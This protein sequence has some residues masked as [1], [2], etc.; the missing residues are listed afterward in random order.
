MESNPGDKVMAT[1]RIMGLCLLAC[2][3]SLTACDCESESSPDELK[4]HFVNPQDGQRLGCLDDKERSTLEQLEFDIEALVILKSADA[5]GLSARLSFGE[6]EYLEEVSFSGQV[7]FK[8]LSLALGSHQLSLSLLEGEEELYAEKI[9][10]EVSFD[11]G[12]PDCQPEKPPAS[13][14]FISP[15]EGKIFSAEDDGEGNLGDGIQI[16]VK[17]EVENA[18]EVRLSLGDEPQGSQAVL[19]GQVSFQ[20]SLP[21]GDGSLTT[22]QLKAEAEEAEALL[23]ISVQVEGCQLSLSPQPTGEACDLSL[24]DDL[25][26][27][28]EGVQVQ[29]EAQTD[30]SDVQFLL[31]GEEVDVV[32]VVEG[33]ARLI[34]TL[35]EGENRISARSSTAGGLSAEYPEYSLTVAGAQATLSLELDELGGNTLTLAEAVA[36]EG[37][38]WSLSGEALAFAP[39]AEISLN[40]EPEMLGFPERV[41]VGADQRISFELETE[42]WCGSLRLSAE[43]SCGASVES[44]LYNLCLEGVQPRLSILS[45]E[46]GAILSLDADPEQEGFQVELQGQVED[47]RPA[48]EYP[49][50]VQ[51]RRAEEES[52]ESVPSEVLNAEE[53]RLM[54]SLETQV[55]GP[56]QCRLWAEPTPNEV[57]SEPRSWILILASPSFQLELPAAESCLGESQLF[58]GQGSQL[59][60][61]QAQLQL[62]LSREGEEAEVWPLEGQGE[63]RYA[64]SFGPEAEH[65]SLPDG[66]YQLSLQG[67]ILG[68]V[69]VVVE[70]ESRSFVVDTTAPVL[71]LLSHEPGAELGLEEDANGDVESDCVQTELSFGVED[72]SAEQGCYRFN[73]GVERCLDLQDGVLQ[74]EQL[75]LIRGENRL[76]LRATDCSGQ[77]TQESFILRATELCPPP[78]LIVAPSNG[79]RLSME[80][81]DLEPETPGLQLNIQ[82]ETGLAEGTEVW[83]E[84]D[85]TQSERGSVDAEGSATLRATI[86]IPD[87]PVDSLLIRLQGQSEGLSGPESSLHLILALPEVELPLLEDCLGA[88]LPDASPD[89]G[90][91]MAIQAQTRLIPEGSEGLLSADCGETSA[92]A[93]AEVDAEGE[94]NLI[95]SLPEEAECQLSLSIPDGIGRVAEAEQALLLDHLPPSVTFR[96]PTPAPVSE[97]SDE[98]PSR[99]GVQL[100]P[101]IEVCGAAGEQLSVLSEQGLLPEGFSWEL[102]E[103]DCVQVPLPQLTLPL[104][105]LA[106]SASVVDSCG[107]LGEGSVRTQVDP[108]ASILITE[109]SDQEIIRITDDLDSERPGCQFDLLA[110]I[111]GLGEETEFQVCTSFEQGAQPDLCG[112][113][114]AAHLEPC[115]MMGDSSVRCPLSLQEGVHTLTLMGRFG[116]ILS[117]PETSIQV[118]C[119]API[120][121]TFRLS[122]EADGCINRADRSNPQ[123]QTDNA[124]LNILVEIEGLEEGQSVQ[125]RSHPDG[126]LLSSAQVSGGQAE[127]VI[128]LAPGNHSLYIQAADPVGNPLPSPEE[129]GELLSFRIDTLV[130]APQLLNLEPESCLNA[131]AD[132]GGAEGFQYAVQIRSGAEQG[133]MVEAQL[134]VGAEQ[135]ALN[136]DQELLTFP[137]MAWA[138]GDLSLDLQVS[139]ACGNVGLIEDLSFR[140][141]SQAPNLSLSGISAGQVFVEADDADANSGNGFQIDLQVNAVELEPAQELRLFSGESRINSDPSPLLQPEG[142]ALSARITLSP[143]EHSISAWAADLCGNEAQSEALSITLDIEGCPA[144]LLG[145]EGEPSIF[146]PNQGAVE[147]GG[148]RLDVAAQVDLFDP[149]CAG[150]GV[151]LLLNGAVLAG[152]IVAGDGAP[153]F[154]NILLPEGEHSLSLRA[155]LGERAT[156]S[157]GRSTIIDL[158]APVVEIID[159]GPQVL[160]DSDPGSPGQQTTV[161]ARITEAPLGSAR[162]ASLA[163]DGELILEDQAVAAESPSILLFNNVSLN[164]GAQELRVCVQDVAGNQGCE[165]LQL[166]ADPSA[167]GELNLSVEI[168]DPRRT[169]IQLSFTAPGE[170][171]AEGGT[172][173]GYEIRRSDSPLDGEQAWEDAEL[174]TRL[175]ADSLELS[176]PGG[177][178]L[179]TL[180][181]LRLNA[182]HHVAVRAFDEI[183]REGPYAQAQVDLELGVSLFRFDGPAGWDLDNFSNSGSVVRGLGSV[184]GDEFEDLLLAITAPV[185]NVA[186]SVVGLIFGGEAGTAAN[187][188]LDPGIA[189]VTA[190]APVGDI[191]GDGVADF[192]IGGLLPTWTGSRISLYFGCAA[193]QEC[194]RDEI[195]NLDAIIEVPGRLITSVEGLGNFRDV[196]GE[197]ATIG[198]LIVGGNLFVVGSDLFVVAGRESWPNSF[199]IS[200]DPNTIRLNVAGKSST[201][202]YTY[203]VPDL[204]GDGYNEALFSTGQGAAG[205]SWLFYGAA[206]PEAVVEY[207]EGNPATLELPHPCPGEA[208]WFGSYL[209][210]GELGGGPGIFVGDKNSKRIAIFGFNDEGVLEGSCFSQNLNLA[211][212]GYIF[213]LAGDI[214]GDGA[215]DL[216]ATHDEPETHGEAYIFYNDGAAHFGQGEGILRAEDLDLHDPVEHKIGVAGVGDFN[217]DGR[218]DVAAVVPLV[219]AVQVVI[220]H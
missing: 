108:G 24:A 184:D 1:Q 112:G 188:T 110:L 38:I 11:P 53:G 167:P 25:D 132:E 208:P 204:N 214:N 60:E 148:L 61:N 86:P 70:P 91:Q 196:A 125:V 183:D 46:E 201:G 139:D 28:S 209:G 197:A 4:I 166:N 88:D 145:F 72:L 164:P 45:P 137:Q 92:E 151:E 127:T 157:P 39:G 187:V 134:S 107:N 120:L 83:I 34:L 194:E 147:A 22:H 99:D 42:Y 161:R 21:V 114:Y 168:T 195:L 103:G 69:A 113:G 174:L 3:S 109:P 162:S 206:T 67:S 7:H 202:N 5:E 160:G 84:I 144:S 40:F 180:E 212:F 18:D 33:R 138:E 116:E 178:Q 78:I 105:E 182:I 121:N 2:V 124:S 36:D 14:S 172:V 123:S 169:E 29:F 23:G 186:T 6:E 173:S 220:Y 165:S 159:P 82:L 93:R 19:N 100:T 79:S 193:P 129:G 106:F 192:A 205:E 189:F 94:L 54:I 71:S 104:G 131:T 15:V 142:G 185:N 191:N 75:D 20:L 101:L 9:Q 59:D 17:L 203:G 8:D 217:H 118:D 26:A 30:C 89:E 170:D 10:I 12:D 155:T 111:S 143:G 37:P 122:A 102:E 171:G 58:E 52:Y 136:S 95:I 98:D 210:A 85:G 62:L 35:E 140:V 51:C 213:D 211:R 115:L 31:N 47:P 87:E 176:A 80:G 64:L 55:S 175:D 177:E 158:S 41:E 50:E 13:L 74:T 200:A 149:E 96:K 135:R 199:D 190:A 156:E 43:D 218:D 77:E 179:I 56:I 181:G 215:I 27:E 126:R 32:G 153:L 16:E 146:G 49:L 44:P 97:F 65:E 133:E 66:H 81:F 68:G 48:P 154:E 163:L 57:L 117:S 219:D 73:G 207:V 152:P 90:F 216:I 76:E 128:S 198:D 141:D 130:P 150:A 119:Q 63:Q